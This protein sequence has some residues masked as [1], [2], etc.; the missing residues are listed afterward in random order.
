MGTTLNGLLLTVFLWS[1]EIDFKI[2]ESGGYVTRVPFSWTVIPAMGICSWRAAICSVK[3][4]P[5]SVSFFMKIKKTYQPA[6]S[7]FRR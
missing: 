3:V 2:S 6:D 7:I 1:L 4:M 5:S